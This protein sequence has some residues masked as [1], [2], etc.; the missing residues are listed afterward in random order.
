MICKKCNQEIP[1]D[2]VFCC[3]C[4]EKQQ[5][6]CLSCGVELVEGAAFCHKCGT[7]VG[8]TVVSTGKKVYSDAHGLYR[9]RNNRMSVGDKTLLFSDYNGVYLLDKD[10]NLKT[11]N[12]SYP[13]AISHTEDTVYVA[14]PDY[15]NNKM[16]LKKYDYDLNLISTSVLCD[17]Y[18]RGDEKKSTISTMN[19]EAYYQV[20]YD[21]CYDADDMLRYQDITLRRVNLESGEETKYVFNELAVENGSVNE[22][23]DLLI[24]GSKIY[25]DGVLRTKN[26]DPDDDD[27]WHRCGAIATFDFDTGKLELL[28]NEDKDLRC[29]RPMFF[30]FAKGIMW[31]R[32]TETENALNHLYRADSKAPLVARKIERNAE[33]LNGYDVWYADGQYSSEQLFYFDG[34][35]AFT[36]PDYYKFHGVD[37]NGNLSES[38]NP[39]GHGRSETAMVWNDMVVADLLADYYYTV[40]PLGFEKPDN[41]NCHMLRHE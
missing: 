18:L 41:S 31:T 6:V 27:T 12:D 7:K 40:Y 26:T 15:D 17:A 20:E 33:I 8:E 11:I 37:R 21:Y 28:W 19:G 22:F 13:K 10:F 39:T 32:V 2:A 24:D 25:I 29:G 5:V 14:M 3:F 16:L 23:D 34:K 35:Y 30:D 1:N 4:G 36:A 9:Q 38:W